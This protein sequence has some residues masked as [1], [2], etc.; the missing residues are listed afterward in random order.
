MEKE[1]LFDLIKRL[2]AIYFAEVLG[3]CIMGNHFHL[4]VRMDIGDGYSD[5]EIKKRFSL[6]FGNDK[7]GE[8][9]ED[10]I[11]FLKRNGLAFRNI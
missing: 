4:L 10:Q 2:S 6:Y 11:S 8:L 1:Y 7:I 3:F 5:E 9:D